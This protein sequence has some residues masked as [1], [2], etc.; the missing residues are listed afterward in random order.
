MG[1]FQKPFNSTRYTR[2]FLRFRNYFVYAKLS[3][4]HGTL[5]TA[6]ESVVF[7]DTDGLS[8]P[9]G[10]LGTSLDNEGIQDLHGLSTPHGTLGTRSL[11]K[12]GFTSAVFQL[13]TVH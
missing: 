4:P 11:L 1:V 12:E 3:T 2:N 7:T 6:N 9:H 8:T 5:G 10:T 13:H